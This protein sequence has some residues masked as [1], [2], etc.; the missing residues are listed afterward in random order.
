M[1]IDSQIYVLTIQKPIPYVKIYGPSVISFTRNK[2]S[3]MTINKGKV[4]NH[5]HHAPQD[6]QL[7]ICR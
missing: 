4:D 2:F 6:N 5:Q 7:H 3:K 1:V